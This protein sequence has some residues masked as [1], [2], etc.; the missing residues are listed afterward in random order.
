MSKFN[1]SKFQLL[2]FLPATLGWLLFSIAAAFV[3]AMCIPSARAADAASVSAPNALICVPHKNFLGLRDG[4]DCTSTGISDLTIATQPHTP[5]KFWCGGPA[6]APTECKGAGDEV[7]RS[8]AFGM[9][10]Q[11]SDLDLAM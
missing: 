3:M 8:E 4:W 6:S 1:L 10:A 5:F 2:R 9:V 11:P 7:V